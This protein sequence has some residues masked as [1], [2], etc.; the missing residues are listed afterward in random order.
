MNDTYVEC[1]VAHKQNPLVPIAKYLLYALAV[2]CFLMSYN[3]LIFFAGSVIFVLIA[4]LVI[5]RLDVEYEY[6]YLSKEISVDKI[7][8][9]EKRKHVM[10]IDLN[11]VEIMAVSKSHSLDSYKNRTHEEKNFASG[12]PD[13]KTY[14]LAYEEQGT[15]ILITLEP[16]EELVGAIKSVFPRKVVEY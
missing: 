11:K 3:N 10:T 8:S 12:N 6:L 5:P 1:L 7:M 4:Y 16:N 15:L 14:T 2:L 13:A 9:K